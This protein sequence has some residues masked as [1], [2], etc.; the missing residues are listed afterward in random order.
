MEPVYHTKVCIGCEQEKPVTEF[1]RST[2]SKDGYRSR[3]KVCRKAYE[4]KPLRITQP[5]LLLLT[6][7]C[8]ICGE[9]KNI[10]EF[11][12]AQSMLYGR[13]KY[14]KKCGAQQSVEYYHTHLEERQEYDRK[15]RDKEQRNANWRKRYQESYSQNPDYMA[16]KYEGRERWRKENLIRVRA[17]ALRYMA[18]KRETTHD[19]VNYEDILLRDG[20]WC[21]LCEQDILPDQKLEFD[22]IIPLLPRVGEP[23]GTH[24]AENIR[25]THK[26]CNRRK[27]NTPLELLTPFQRRGPGK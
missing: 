15:K 17:Y 19:P 27:S 3:C 5:P 14:C 20:F 8:R 22:H 16:T 25:P 10:E 13:Q 23:Q 7:A 24:T 21:Y 4:A 1:N 6:Q 18:K 2:Q 9:E 12:I 11:A 26:I